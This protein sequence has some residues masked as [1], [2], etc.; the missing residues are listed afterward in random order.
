MPYLF[1]KDIDISTGFDYPE[2]TPHFYG[3]PVDKGYLKHESGLG[4]EKPTTPGV[5][6]AQLVRFKTRRTE[7]LWK[8]HPAIKLFAITKLSNK[9]HV[10]IVQANDKTVRLCPMPETNTYLAEVSSNWHYRSKIIFN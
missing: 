10:I 1:Q 3:E 5:Q 4:G 7:T 8:Q 9:H 2:F 6:A